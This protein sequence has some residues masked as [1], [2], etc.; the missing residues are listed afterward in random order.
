[1]VVGEVAGVGFQGRWWA[2]TAGGGGDSQGT[3]RRK[4][5][6]EWYELQKN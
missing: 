2:H 4:K 5:V 1:M 3:L 6:D